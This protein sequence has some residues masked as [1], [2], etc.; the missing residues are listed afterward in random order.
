MSLVHLRISDTGWSQRTEE[1]LDVDFVTIAF[2]WNKELLEVVIALKW[3]KDIDLSGYGWVQRWKVKLSLFNF[4]PKAA[5]IE[6]HNVKTRFIH[7]LKK[8]I[9]FTYADKVKYA[10]K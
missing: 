1:F 2:K 9:N 7:V 6:K 3:N 8:V 10:P 4:L 5:A